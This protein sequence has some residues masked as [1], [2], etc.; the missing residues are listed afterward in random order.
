MSEKVEGFFA[1]HPEAIAYIL[2]ILGIIGLIILLV[3]WF[4]KKKKEEKKKE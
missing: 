2:A 4:S 1:K 3:Y